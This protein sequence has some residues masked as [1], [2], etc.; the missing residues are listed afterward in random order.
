MWQT[1]DISEIARGNSFPFRTAKIQQA[2]IFA[3]LRDFSVR[4]LPDEALEILD[5]QDEDDQHSAEIGAGE[6]SNE[7]DFQTSLDESK[8]EMA[9]FTLDKAD[10]QASQ[11]SA[12]QPAP[13]LDSIRSEA[14]AEGREAARTEYEQERARLSAANR[15]ALVEN[16]QTV[17]NSLAADLVEICAKGFADLQSCLQENLAQLIAPLVGEKLTREAAAEFVQTLS[18]ETIESHLPL[19]IEGDPAL[20]NAFIVQAKNEPALDIN[21]YQLK[22]EAGSALTLVVKDQM[23]STRIS[24]LLQQ[25]REII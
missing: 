11:E 4:Q 14:F 2:E 21:H 19:I 17:I 22:A 6:G 25:L 13:D 9:P 23:L 15:Q 20:L 7:G 8:A 24:P 5:P 1:L 3:H 10:G 18:R 16:R 12:A